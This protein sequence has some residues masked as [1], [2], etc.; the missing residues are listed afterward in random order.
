VFCF[1]SEQDGHPQ[2]RAFAQHQLKGLADQVKV[3]Q[4]GWIDEV[5]V[6]GVSTVQGVT[7]SADVLYIDAHRLD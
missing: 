1:Y 4:H 7:V 5:I 3:Q 6:L 2:S